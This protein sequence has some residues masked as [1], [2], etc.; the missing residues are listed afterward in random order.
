MNGDDLYNFTKRKQTDSYAH[1]FSFSIIKAMFLGSFA[2][3]AALV[4]NSSMQEKS[5]VTNNFVRKLKIEINGEVSGVEGM[6]EEINL[7]QWFL[8]LQENYRKY[9][10]QAYNTALEKTSD[11]CF[12]SRQIQCGALEEFIPRVKNGQIHPVID[13]DIDDTAKSLWYKIH[14]NLEQL[15]ESVRD[16]E[17]KEFNEREKIEKQFKSEYTKWQ[18]DMELWKNEKLNYEMQQRTQE[19]NKLFFNKKSTSSS[20]EFL[21][22]PLRPQPSEPIEPEYIKQKLK[23]DIAELYAVNIY[24]R[25]MEIMLYIKKSIEKFRKEHTPFSNVRKDLY[26]DNEDV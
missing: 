23:S 1:T 15:V 11:L 2:G 20:D 8:F 25:N 12:T 14:D 9:N 22:P 10:Q 3:L 13:I 19:A 4:V 21:L 17:R 18:H 24:Q 7:S 6:D 16:S 5:A 26:N